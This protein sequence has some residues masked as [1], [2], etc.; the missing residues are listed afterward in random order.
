M[1]DISTPADGVASEDDYADLVK[2][3]AR[4]RPLSDVNPGMP[5]DKLADLEKDILSNGQDLPIILWKGHDVVIDGWHRLQVCL[6]HDVQP[7]YV[8]LACDA[9]EAARLSRSYNQIRRQL[10]PGQCAAFRVLA[11]EGEAVVQRGGDRSVRALV[12]RTTSKQ[13]AAEAE[14]S[15]SSLRSVRKIRKH[16]ATYFT[17][18]LL[19]EL[20]IN[21][22]KTLCFP[23]EKK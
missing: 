8:E 17:Q 7:K 14:V 4:L 1:T 11:E 10:T 3:F 16:C 5:P 13:R 18:L 15:E 21:K 23:R 2:K 12:G 6:A 22:A 20:T 19:G 9:R